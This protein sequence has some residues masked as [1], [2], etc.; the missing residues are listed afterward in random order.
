VSFR[1]PPGA[2]IAPGEA[3]DLFVLF[4]GD[5]LGYVDACG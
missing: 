2:L 1:P 5:V 3:P 4:T